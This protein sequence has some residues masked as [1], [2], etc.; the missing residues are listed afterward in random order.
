MNDDALFTLLAD[1]TRRRI[2]RLLLAEGEL[3]VCE[4]V[5]ALDTDQPKASRHLARM[6]AAG[7]VEDRRAAQWMLYRVA[8]VARAP[9]AALLS[10]AD[11][12]AG[13]EAHAADRARL[14]AMTT[15]P[16]RATRAA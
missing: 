13:P 8:K 9:L 15:R 2:L 5:A 11:A 3:C 12:L 14:A 16:P 7:L 4:L 10:A 6:R 1:A